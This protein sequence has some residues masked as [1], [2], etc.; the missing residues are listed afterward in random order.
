[1]VHDS[2]GMP[3]LDFVYCA[4]VV[5]GIA[6]VFSPGLHSVV[7]CFVPEDTA[8]PVLCDS[9]VLLRVSVWRMLMS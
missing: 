8:P 9:E 5:R 3:Y 2:P 6:P 7:M 1:M 4:T